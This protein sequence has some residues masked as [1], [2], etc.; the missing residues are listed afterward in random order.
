MGHCDQSLGLVV[1]RAHEDGLVEVTVKAP[2]VDCYV[3]CN[4]GDGGGYG[5][6]DYGD[7]VDG[8]GGKDKNRG[9]GGGES[10]RCNE[11]CGRDGSEDEL[12]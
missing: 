1:H 2:V 7:G 10:D 5:D 12:C 9:D 4:G 3:D 6:R 8:G 11:S